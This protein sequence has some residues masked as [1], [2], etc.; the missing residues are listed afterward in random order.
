MRRFLITALAV[1][2]LAGGWRGTPAEAQPQTA[3][4]VTLAPYETLADA[5]GTIGGLVNQP[6]LPQTLELAITGATA[7]HGL[8]GI[9][10]QRPLG[11]LVLAE[12]DDFHVV[13]YLPVDDMAALTEMLEAASGGALEATADGEYELE[14]DGTTLFI[15]EEN[16]WAAISDH[17][18]ALD[19]AP[20]DPA[21]E[22]GQLPVRYL[23]AARGLVANIPEEI[24]AQ[25]LGMLQMGMAAGMQPA[26]GETPEQFELRRQMTEQ[27]V[28]QWET[29]IDETEAV[30]V[31]LAFDDAVNSVK[32]DMELFARPGTSL[33]EQYAAMEGLT[34]RFA[35]FEN[36]EALVAMLATQVMTENDQEAAKAW[37]AALE[38]QIVEELGQEL[39]EEQT[40]RAEQILATIVEVIDAS[41]ESG[42]SDVGGSLLFENG[43][44]VLVAGGFVADGAKLEGAVKDLVDLAV[45]DMPELDA[46]VE[47]DA[48]THEGV[49]LHRFQI[50]LDSPDLAELG[51]LLG[52]PVTVVVGFGAEAAYL[53]VGEGAQ[54]RLETAISAVQPAAADVPVRM[55]IS[56]GGL[57]QVFVQTAEEPFMKMMLQGI[58]QS[59]AEHPGRDRIMMT[60][61]AIPDGVRTTVTVEQ[62]VVQLI[63][64]LVEVFGAMFGGFGD[65][66]GPP[67]GGFGPGF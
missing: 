67:P 37:I 10:R 62:G 19:A 38:G 58:Q 59:L 9:D 41:I 4:V 52:D 39:T 66:A 61:E 56:T 23:V 53:A 36:E 60:Q 21:A 54:A 45:E 35:A 16:G 14:A 28:A 17:R 5:L 18:E 46:L 13:V 49:S 34:T 29:L 40:E 1:A 2:L 47:L 55:T 64:G 63:A 12:A 8:A 11:A 33:A 32:L 51:E 48:E 42:Q 6:E 15:R 57:L 3:A 50:P 30:M 65:P 22:F 44:L 7:G 27:N 26:P 31:G 24:R 20:L 25:A 43:R